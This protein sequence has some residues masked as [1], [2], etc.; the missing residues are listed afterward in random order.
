MSAFTPA[1]VLAQGLRA[2]AAGDLQA[3]ERLLQQALRE[4]PGS[5][6]ALAALGQLAARRR[7]WPEAEAAF[8]ASLQR[9]PAQ[10]RVWFARAQM[11]EMLQRPTDAALSFAQ[12][13]ERQAGWAA[14][15]YELARLLREL[16]R[17]PQAL[18]AAREAVQLAPQDAN[19]LQLL[20]MLQEESG[21]LAAAHASL[22]AALT[23]APQRA[24]L[25]HNLGVVLHR[26][27]RHAAALAAHE[28]ALAL[29]LDV[30]EAH[31]NLGNTLHALG[32]AQDALAAYR[33]ALTLAPQHALSL[34]DLAKLRWVLGHDD[35]DAELLAAQQRFPDSDVAPGLRGLLLLRAERAEAA[36]Q[37]YELAA[38]RAPQNAAYVDGQGQA[39]SLLGRHQEA[40][41]AHRR[42]VALAPRDVAVL[43]N[44][45]RS[46]YAAGQT[47]EALALAEQA[48]ALAPDDQHAI[49]LLGV[50]WR[51]SGDP[52]EAW[53]HDLAQ[54]V[55]VIDLPPPPGW[56]DMASFNAALAEELGRLH[57]DVEA[58]I[59]QTL[60]R[61]TQTRGNLFDLE[62]P[63]VQALRRQIEAAITTWLADRPADA[64][65]PLLGRRT[66][67]WKFSDSWSSRL[68]SSGFHTNHVHGHGWLSSCYYVA[69]PP[70]ALA[71]PAHAGWIKFGEPDLPE[72]VRSALPPVRFEAPRPGRLLLF[73][74]YLWHGT[75]PFEDEA[76]RLT[77]AFDVLPA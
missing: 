71:S 23:Q 43:T 40:C 69:T 4:A 50:G 53:L 34:Y 20:A 75:V 57:T 54:L 61:G 72:P 32:R 56:T 58:P 37:A 63:L 15:R 22:Q 12:A 45:A 8:A 60:R 59:D 3:A 17:A 16:G 41:A 28:R 19:A 73:P 35:F 48:H 51:L 39:L 49:A 27:G 65:H 30:A 47:N 2:L 38:L 13:G 76:C 44:A 6:P 70:S 77:V 42:A 55:G 66:G 29:G 24:A 5:P 74:S 21:D 14:P 67:A 52:R 18:V 31:Y 7:Q 25:H 26:Q 36:L 11:L 62:L 9:D 46:L 10:P 68:R 1:S 64:A 33:R